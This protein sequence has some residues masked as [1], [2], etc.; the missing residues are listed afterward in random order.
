MTIDP[1]L[2]GLGKMD[3][4]RQKQLIYCRITLNS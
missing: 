3:Q 1:E 2:P 4:D